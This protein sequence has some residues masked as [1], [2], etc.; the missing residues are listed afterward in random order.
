M[1]SLR[2]PPTYH[3]ELTWTLGRGDGGTRPGVTYFVPVPLPAA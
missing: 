1:G 3:G 2:P